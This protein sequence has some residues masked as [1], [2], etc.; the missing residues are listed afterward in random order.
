MN[1]I[2]SIKLNDNSCMPSL[3]LYSSNIEC[4]EAYTNS[5]KNQVVK[6]KGIESLIEKRM[7]ILDTK[8]EYDI[9]MTQIHFEIDFELLGCNAKSLFQSIYKQIEEYKDLNKGNYIIVCK[10]FHKTNSDLLDCMY[11]YIQRHFLEEQTHFVWIFET[12][13]IA[14]IPKEI[15]NFCFC[16]GIKNDLKKHTISIE[17][18]KD[19]VIDVIDNFKMRSINKL[20]EVL[21]DILIYQIDFHFLIKELIYNYIEKLTDE[22]LM[23]MNILIMK[24]L[25]R[26]NNNYRPIFH[27]ETIIL[28]LIKLINE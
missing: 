19:E 12:E 13:S 26:Y 18:I 20:R 2:K 1:L 11:S 7:K 6:D 21:Y 27:L 24:Y 23:K 5:L 8:D 3:I 28:N 15:Y 9:K 25:K 14:I 16:I 17:K 4:C 10:N 22:N